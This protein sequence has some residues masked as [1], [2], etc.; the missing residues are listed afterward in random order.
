VA[1]RLSLL[2]AAIVAT[3]GLPVALASAMTV[4]T[5]PP[6]EV[7]TNSAR[8]LGTV[9]PEGAEI[10]ECVFEWGRE[11]GGLAFE[12]SDSTPCAEG[13]AEIGTGNS[14]VAVHADI[15]NLANGSY[16]YRLRAKNGSVEETSST[17][18]FTTTGPT[19]RR[20]NAAEISETSAVLNG[21]IDPHGQE[22]TY[23]FE[24]VSDAEFANSGYS[25]ASV[26]PVGG[27]FISGEEANQNR[28]EV[29]QEISG[30]QP[31]TIYHLRLVATNLEG[32][33]VGND[34]AVKTF[35][36]SP[37]GP[38]D[39]RA[40]EQVTPYTALGKNANALLGS[41]YLSAASPNGDAATYYAVTGAGETESGAQYPIYVAKRGPD[42]WVSDGISPPGSTGSIL[43]QLDYTRSLLGAYSV[44]STPGGTASLYRREFGGKLFLI[45]SEITGRRQRIYVSAESADEN[46]VLFES[47]GLLT[48]DAVSAARNAYIWDKETGSLKLV[49]V[50]PDG[51]VP[52]SGGFA[53]SWGRE[54]SE[55]FY[56]ETALS[57]DGTR[58]FFTTADTDQIYLRE[59]PAKDSATT[60]PISASQKTNGSGPGGTDPEGPLPASF[61]EATPSGSYVFFTSAEDLTN[62]A[63]TGTGE[64]EDLYRYDVATGK[65]SDLTAGN[66][67]PGGPQVLGTAGISQDGSYVYFVARGQLAP[68]APSN[69]EPGLYV[70]H[71][72]NIEFIS[73]VSGLSDEEIWFNATY[74]FGQHAQRAARVAPNGQT[75]VFATY[76]PHPGY[77]NRTKTED[78]VQEIYRYEF[79]SSDLQCL[80]C[81]PTGASAEGGASLQAIP[82]PFIAPSAFRAKTTRNMSSDGRRV[83]FQTDES[84]LGR[85]RNGVADVY[86]WEEKGKGSCASEE[87]N[88]GCLSLI[89]TGTSPE[90]SYLSDASESGDDVFFFTTQRL[91]GQ[92]KDELSD[93]YDARVGGGLA[94][95][96]PPPPNPCQGE[97]CLGASMASP[98][99]PT[100]GSSTFSGPGNEKQTE[101]KRHRKHRKKHKKHT[102]RH[103]HAGGRQR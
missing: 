22:T 74:R 41:E 58:A 87:Q 37:V 44:A 91:V 99:T 57:G 77:D 101:H 19:I 80:S 3:L 60:T 98:A 76:Q 61:L 18:Q 100:P 28:V 12:P 92:D 55:R 26:V 29:R 71:D 32:T 39:G 53:G 24:Y 34:K 86:E 97:A 43:T 21:Q 103:R 36:P 70:W 13:P 14:P 89:S 25:G 50:L 9:T 79:G 54:G 8:L 7:T 52:S 75:I 5:Q 81:S 49:D 73:E 17:T 51:S 63:N 102:K 93:L 56:S 10:E 82:R 78:R 48:E 65:L 27:A 84:L 66:T 16:I 33:S 94:A 11:R 20:E 2:L 4:T 59:N 30:L 85:D 47:P 15:S 72:G 40:Y 35:G 67:A 90:P 68:G 23:F 31:L 42:G 6:T 69:G 1:G 45:A 62:D 46:L 88:G 38:P 83:V 95:Q 96:N 64:G